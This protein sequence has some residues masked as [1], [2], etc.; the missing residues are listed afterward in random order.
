MNSGWK[1]AIDRD[2]RSFLMET[3]TSNTRTSMS[4]DDE[5]QQY[6]CF[7][8][9][10]ITKDPMTNPP[11]GTEAVMSDPQQNTF[12]FCLYRLLE[13]A[14]ADQSLGSI[15]SWLPNGLGFEVHNKEK[16]ARDV[17]PFYFN[18]NKYKSFQRQLNLYK[19]ERVRSNPF[20][21]KNDI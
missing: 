15:I 6:G 3:P 14:E 2:Q 12:P 10:S 18:Q 19:F 1:Q 9:S 20:K 8:I 4:I 17:I 16:L 13:Q 21:G 5:N 7:Y 11:L